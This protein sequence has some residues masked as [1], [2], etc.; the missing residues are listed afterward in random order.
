[1]TPQSPQRE[2]RVV[3][4]RKKKSSKV[5][6]WICLTA[7]GGVLSWGAIYLLRFNIINGFKRANQTEQANGSEAEMGASGS[8]KASHAPRLGVAATTIQ[9]LFEQPNIG[10]TFE[11]PSPVNGDLRLIGTSAHGL[12]TI[13]LIGQPENLTCATIMVSIP[14]DNTHAL[15]LN[16]EYVLRFIKN[17]SPHWSGGGDWVIQNLDAFASGQRTEIRTTQAGQ[18]IS[19]TLIGEQEFLKITVKAVQ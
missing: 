9:S 7:I 16:A 14:D 12:A 1:M 10:F 5:L 13:E 15:T 19:M 11:N 17:L 18:E 2:V 8:S 4:G 3:G 6:R